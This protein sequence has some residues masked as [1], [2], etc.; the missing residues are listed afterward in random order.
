MSIAPC[1][2]PGC[3]DH[4]GDL[5]LTSLGMCEQCQRRYRRVLWWLV[6]DWVHLATTMAAPLRTA[7]AGRPTTGRVYGHPAEW[8]SDTATQVADRLNDLHDDLSDHLHETPPPNPYVRDASRVR[9]AWSYLECRV[10]RLATHP[11]ATDLALEVIELHGR[12]RARLGHTR[13]C[14]TLP[15]N[16]P[17]CELRTVVRTIDPGQD[18]VSCQ[19]CG[20]FTREENYGLFARMIIDAM[21]DEDTCRCGQQNHEEPGGGCPGTGVEGPIDICQQHDETG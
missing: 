14:Y 6:L 1:I 19:N 4:H 7:T 16:C 2:Y 9:A 11:A 18:L 17:D 8:A 3:V 12:I 20:W 13:P 21:I 10:D 5:R 15:L